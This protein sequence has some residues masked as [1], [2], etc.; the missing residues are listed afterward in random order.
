[1]NVEHGDVALSD[2][3][4]RKRQSCAQHKEEERAR[5]NKETFFDNLLTAR[6]PAIYED[7]T[8]LRHPTHRVAAHGRTIRPEHIE[9][10]TSGHIETALKTA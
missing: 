2:Q 9:G 3:R 4:M 7:E 10:A 6:I 1:M 8:Y 5:L